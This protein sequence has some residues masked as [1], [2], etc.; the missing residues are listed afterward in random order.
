M[1]GDRKFK[2][3]QSEMR[4][5]KKAGINGCFLLVSARFLTSTN[6]PNG[7]ICDYQG[8][9]GVREGTTNGLSR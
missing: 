7:L 9:L 1:V 8:L 3:L 6:G 4:R 5:K 2:V